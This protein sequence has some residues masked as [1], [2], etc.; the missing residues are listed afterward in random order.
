MIRRLRIK[1]VCINMVIVTGMLCMIFGMVLYVTRVNLEQESL[2]M[3]RSI[4]LDT[5]RLPIP[6]EGGP[7][8]RL[9]HFILQVGPDDKIFV[10]DGGRYDLSDQAMLNQ[11]V[12]RSSGQKTGVLK[13]YGLRYIRIVTPTTQRLIFADISSE[14]NTMQHLLQN[15]LFI[16]VISFLVFL[17]I[18][19][20][21][22]RWAVKPVEAA[23]EQQR[24]FVADASHELKT[25]LT[26]ILSNAQMLAEC[27][28]DPA[29]QKKL[30][31][32]ILTVSGQM[33][34]L[35][36]RL[37]NAAKVDQGPEQMMFS[38]VDLSGIVERALLTFDPIFYARELELTTSLQKGICVSGSPSH[39]TQMVDILLDNAQKYSTPYGL[40]HV[41]LRAQGKKRCILTVENEGPPMTDQELRQIFKRFYRADSA[42]ERTGSYGLGLPIAEGIV[43]AHRGKIRAESRDGRN[44]FHIQLPTI[45]AH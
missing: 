36:T 25:P 35:V 3:M 28:S 41:T 2:G 23:W 8:C 12:S 5:A 29:L 43:K 44:R 9:P 38:Q 33:K 15:C 34:D 6:G 22:A 4:A 7:E 26:V 16:G 19:I 17:V 30:T 24:K 27:G 32:N 11:L 45:P 20:L 39:L 40:T 31:A 37:L 21:L 13:D 42:R 14:I 1:F 10:A 18:S